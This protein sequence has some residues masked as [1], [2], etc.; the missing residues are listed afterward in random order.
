MLLGKLTS[1]TPISSRQDLANGQLVE[2]E[3]FCVLGLRASG[4]EFRV[5]SLGVSRS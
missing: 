3:G 5:Q 2:A 1:C 4:L